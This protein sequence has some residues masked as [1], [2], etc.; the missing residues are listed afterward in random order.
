MVYFTLHNSAGARK[1]IIV[2]IRSSGWANSITSQELS[3][4]VCVCVTVC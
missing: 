1:Q 4:R 3:V 2:F